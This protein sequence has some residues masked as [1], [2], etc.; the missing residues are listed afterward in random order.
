MSIF[1]EKLAEAQAITAFPPLKGGIE[2]APDPTFKMMIVDAA[3]TAKGPQPKAVWSPL[4]DPP[5]GYLQDAADTEF[6]PVALAPIAE[7]EQLRQQ[8]WL[9]NRQSVAAYHADSRWQNL[10]DVESM[11]GLVLVI[12]TGPS[13]GNLPAGLLERAHSAG[14]VLIGVNQVADYVD[15]TLLDYLVVMSPRADA[16]WWIDKSFGCTRKV[17]FVGT[18]P[19]ITWG[20]SRAL[21][22]FNMA[23]PGCPWFRESWT[24]YPGLPLLQSGNSVAVQAYN[25]ACRVPGVKRIAMLGVDLS[26]PGGMARPGQADKSTLGFSAPEICGGRVKTETNLYA[27]VLALTG[28]AAFAAGAGIET[29]NAT[30]R[31]LLGT[32]EMQGTSGRDLSIK[33]SSLEDLLKES[34]A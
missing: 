31:G 12:A 25:L 3:I 7:S 29:H 11:T 13:L 5:T 28:L 27:T 32:I 17:A 18:N 14:A 8:H 2:Y 6:D 33:T 26:Y 15:P 22:W 19:M 24:N 20:A 16:A 21:H 9:V 34:K 1:A 4:V 30:G 10:F 23:Q